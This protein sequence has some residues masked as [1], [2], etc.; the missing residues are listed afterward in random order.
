[1]K[2]VGGRAE[3]PEHVPVV[4]AR[5]R[6]GRPD[7]GSSKP[8]AGTSLGRDLKAR[9]TARVFL[10]GTLFALWAGPAG[11][12][13]PPAAT[14]RCVSR[15]QAFPGRCPTL[16]ENRCLLLSRASC[17]GDAGTPAEDTFSESQ[18]LSGCEAFEGTL[19]T[20]CLD[21]RY[22]YW[23]CLRRLGLPQVSCQGGLPNF[24][25]APAD[26]C[27]GERT[28]RDRQCPPVLIPDAGDLRDAP[29]MTGDANRGPADASIQKADATFDGDLPMGSE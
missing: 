25:A 19:Q 11:C 5:G 6:P 1:M 28:Q 24:V 9:R 2:P 4:V 17:K 27:S 21:A 29:D 14:T 15:G 13:T 12:D 10:G 26:A 22:V 7:R 18:C 3:R 20:T 23:W 16:C 8:L